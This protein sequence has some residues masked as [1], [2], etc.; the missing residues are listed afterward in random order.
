MNLCRRLENDLP[1]KRI[2]FEV[3]QDI[4]C[5]R[6]ASRAGIQHRMAARQRAR[7]PNGKVLK[8]ARKMAPGTMIVLET[9]ASLLE[10]VQALGSARA[11]TSRLNGRKQDR[12]QNTDDG[13]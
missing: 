10:V 11:L 1:V 3:G 12:H 9:H 7:N 4:S 2:L 13:N 8:P 6:P 5:P